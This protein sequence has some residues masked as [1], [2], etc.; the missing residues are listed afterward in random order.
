MA[1]ATNFASVQTARAGGVIATVWGIAAALAVV[2]VLTGYQGLTLL[3]NDRTLARHIAELKAELTTLEA[4]GTAV[5][6]AA[7]YDALRARITYQNTLL[8]DRRT[9]L[10]DILAAL[11]AAVPADVWLRE[12]SYDTPT[13]RL[14]LSLLSRDETALPAALQSIEAIDLLQ[15]VILKR[16]VQMRQGQEE[17]VQYEVEGVAR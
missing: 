4:T 6:S 3:D 11:E 12:L 2:C 10:M 5:P 1:R 15:D 17:L 9:E 7:D 16:Q 13:G 8:G 14:S